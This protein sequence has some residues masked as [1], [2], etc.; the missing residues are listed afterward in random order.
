M[1]LLITGGCGFIGTNFIRLLLAEKPEWTVVNLDALTYA[2]NPHNLDDLYDCD[3]IDNF[4][5][6]HNS[7]F[8]H[9]D[10]ADKGLVEKILTEH[11][12]SH[13]VNF[14]AESHVDRSIIDASPFI[15]TNILGTQV[16]LD[17]ARKKGGCRFV[18]VST[19]EVYGS[20][21]KDGLFREEDP[22]KPNSPYAASKASAD[23][24][25]RAAN[26]TFD[27]DTVITRCSNN[28]GPYQ[29]PEKFIPL[30]ITRSLRD[31]KLPIYG[32]GLQVRD[33]IHV[34]DHCRGI[35]L[36][37]EKGLSGKIYNFGANTER[38]NL[39]LVTSI[40][41]LLN[42]P[43]SL[44]S[45]VADRLGHDRRYAIDFSSAQK[46]LG[47]QPKW[48]FEDGLKHCIEWYLNNPKWVENVTSGAYRTFCKTLY[49]DSL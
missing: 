28:Y 23:L 35:L 25:V 17:A 8:V 31:E 3:T 49:G 36:A 13:I 33:W 4:S 12:I 10:I 11:D 19:D 30:C 43:T 18:Q 27:M 38:T 37:L 46:E 47:Y 21:G 2:G 39:E 5:K 14:A 41:H 26:K 9:G 34:E 7:H 20:L 44:I 40:L 22:L 16:L 42:K 29:F 32:D 45:H 24:L 48:N 6:R 1:N 15:H